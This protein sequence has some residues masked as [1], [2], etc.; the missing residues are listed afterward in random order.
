MV[1]REKRKASEICD[2][3]EVEMESDHKSFVFQRNASLVF[4]TTQT[5]SSQSAVRQGGE[6]V[7]SGF[8]GVHSQTLRPSHFEFACPPCLSQGSVRA[9]WLPLAVQ[10]H[11]RQ[12]Y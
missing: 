4:V 12:A 5:Q 7:S 11:A 6:V 10:K 9:R 3:M 2:G 8:R 1:G